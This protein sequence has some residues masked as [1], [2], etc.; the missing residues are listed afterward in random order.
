MTLLRSVLTLVLLTA[1]NGKGFAMSQCNE[2]F[3][4]V[5]A[6]QEIEYLRRW[7]AKATD[8]I[9]TATEE[10]IEAGRKIYHR[11]FAKDVVITVS[12]PG[13]EPIEARGPDAWV[14]LPSMPSENSA[15]PSILLVPR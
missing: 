6:T 5:E 15:P 1:F 4:R 7:Y 10:Q 3:A 9:G 8:L 14:T 11:I 13:T 12:G 2:G